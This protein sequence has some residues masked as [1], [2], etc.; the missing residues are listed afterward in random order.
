MTQRNGDAAQ[1]RFSDTGPAA[2][3]FSLVPLGRGVSFA[4]VVL[5]EPTQARNCHFGVALDASFA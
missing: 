3:G 5:Y 2:T 1:E 4:P